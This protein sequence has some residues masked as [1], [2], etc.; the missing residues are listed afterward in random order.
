MV[1]YETRMIAIAHGAV[2]AKL[3]IAALGDSPPHPSYEPFI[4]VIN[5]AYYM[6]MLENQTLI[7]MKPF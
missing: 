2:T 4:S 5:W 3:L 6:R 7:H 1:N